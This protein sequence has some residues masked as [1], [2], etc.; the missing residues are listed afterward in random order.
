MQ[1]DLYDLLS[2]KSVLSNDTRV[3]PSHLCEPAI[4]SGCQQLKAWFRPHASMNP[5]RSSYFIDS[6]GPC[7]PLRGYYD[8]LGA[9]H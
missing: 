2:P 1:L 7:E 8:T 3:V 9:I 5:S 6:N 4:Q